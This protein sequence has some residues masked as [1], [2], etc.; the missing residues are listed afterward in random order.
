M[1]ALVRGRDLQFDRQVAGHRETGRDTFFFSP[2][3]EK[4]TC[5][6]SPL[7]CYTV[8]T[9][10]RYFP[11]QPFPSAEVAQANELVTRLLIGTF[12]FSCQSSEVLWQADLACLTTLLY[13][14]R[15]EPFYGHFS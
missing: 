8:G 11:A 7:L 9:R 2:N 15:E 1:V 3:S 10:V 5:I 13:S 14:A 4:V 6:D 12:G